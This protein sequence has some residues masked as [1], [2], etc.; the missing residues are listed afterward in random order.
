MVEEQGSPAP[1]SVVESLINELIG[2][3]RNLAELAGY[4]EDFE[5]EVKE[6]ERAE[7][8]FRTIRDSLEEELRD[9]S[10]AVER[11]SGELEKEISE[12]KRIEEEF[13]GIR[14]FLEGQL[15]ARGAELERLQGE[16]Q[17][18]VDERKQAVGNLEQSL[19]QFRSLLDSVQ[20]IH[21]K[22]DTEAS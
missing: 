1:S 18:E 14:S 11:L 7:A 4:K 6:R 9:R 12:R 20:Q 2:M 10:A 8:E 5:R 17:R 16:L 3:R 15:A 13:S 19:Q 21:A 22:L